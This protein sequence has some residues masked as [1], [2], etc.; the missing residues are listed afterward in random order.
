MTK[1]LENINRLL[2]RRLVYHAA[3]W[4]VLL[5]ILTISEMRSGDEA[6]G[7]LFVNELINVFF[8]AL[9]YYI[10]SDY[11]I[12]KYLIPNK[13]GQYLG[14]LVAVAVVLTPIKIFILFQRFKGSA[15]AQD[16]LIDHQPYYYLISM[17]TA[18]VST[19]VK[20]TS[21]WVKQSQMNRE[22]ETRTMQT[23]LN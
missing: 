14:F 10:N 18:G 4:F 2:T 3:F 21:D 8:Y 15:S 16:F 12:P 1:M 23:E 19:I 6:F 17:M 13:L 20:I 11:L 22:L 7:R 5:G 9:I